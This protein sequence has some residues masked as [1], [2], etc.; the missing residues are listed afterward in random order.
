M[1]RDVQSI[2]GNVKV[3][4]IQRNYQ[5]REAFSNFF[6]LIKFDFVIDLDMTVSYLDYEFVSNLPD[7]LFEKYDLDK[8]YCSVW[9]KG[10]MGCFATEKQIIK[11][12][13]EKE[14]G[15]LTIFLDDGVPTNCWEKKLINAYNS[16]PLDWDALILGTR[17]DKE[18]YRSIRPIIHFKRYMEKLIFKKDR[19]IT[20]TFN[21]KLDIRNGNINGIFGIIYS[22][23]GLRKLV[24]EPEKLR[25]DQDDILISRLTSTGYL[26]VYIAYPQIVK[27][28]EYDGSWTQKNNFNS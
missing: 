4:S 14:M 11:Q 19:F 20:K 1:N 5:K 15:N 21:R 6:K 2:L 18:T 28:G 3:I 12:F 26:K 23:N 7:I 22:Q 16:L 17:L 8:N 27:E 9:S 24:N 25:K 13:H 10:Q